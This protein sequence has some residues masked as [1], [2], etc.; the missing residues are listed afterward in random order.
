MIEREKLICML[1]GYYSAKHPNTTG[2]DLTIYLDQQLIE[3]NQP[4]LG[5]EDVEL[6]DSLLAETMIKVLGSG[7]NRKIRR[8]IQ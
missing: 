2:M 3:A 8:S 7:I 1:V 6:L 4:K 5:K